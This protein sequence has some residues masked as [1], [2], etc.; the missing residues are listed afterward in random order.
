MMLGG[1]KIYQIIFL[2]FKEIG[3]GPFPPFSS[4]VDYFALSEHCTTST[5]YLSNGIMKALAEMAFEI[6]G[7]LKFHL[8]TFNSMIIY[9]TG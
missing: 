7:R 3:P 2:Y 5:T 4:P 1:H 6:Q 9:K 8:S